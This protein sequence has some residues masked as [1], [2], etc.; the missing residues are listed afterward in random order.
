MK[1]F[2]LIKTGFVKKRLIALFHA[3]KDSGIRIEIKGMDILKIKLGNYEFS[4]N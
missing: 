1:E 2:K 4:K 3:S